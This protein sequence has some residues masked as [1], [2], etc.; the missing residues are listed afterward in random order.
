MIDRPVHED[1][2]APTAAKAVGHGGLIFVGCWLLLGVLGFLDYVTGYEMSFFV[3]YSVPVGVGAWWM[4]RWSA[5]GLALGATLT[6][7]MADY[8]SGAK[9]SAPFFYYWNSTIHFTAFMI[10][11]VTIAKIKSDLDRRNLLAAELESTRK[12]LRELSSLLTACPACARPRIATGENGELRFTAL[13]G[14]HPELAEMLCTDCRP[15]GRQAD[16]ETNQPRPASASMTSKSSL[17]GQ[18]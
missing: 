17:K 12:A 14:E 13:V 2:E 8:L 7:L 16:T 6:W 9:Y 10:N 18:T 4:G 11:A 3:F 1:G 5:I 15:D